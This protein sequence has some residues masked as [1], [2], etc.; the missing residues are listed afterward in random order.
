MLRWPRAHS[1][2]ISAL[3]RQPTGLGAGIF[4]IGY[5]LLEVP[6]NLAA[7]RVGPRP[8]IARIAVTWGALSTAMMFVPGELSFYVLRVL[9]GVAEAGL[10]PALMYMVTLWFAPKDRRGRRGLDLYRSFHCAHYR[11]S[12][13]CGADATGRNRRSA[14]LAVDVPA[15]RSAHHRGRHHPLFQ[16]AGPA[17][18]R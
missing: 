3:V 6:S 10:F 1:R 7:H 13:R 15:G 5:A 18:S 17:Q 8:W 12:A 16:A 14:R 4:F 9:L 11:Q 2:P